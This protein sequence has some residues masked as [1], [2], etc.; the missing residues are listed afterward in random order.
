M[1]KQDIAV[2]GLS[3]LFPG[4]DT[5]D[6]FWENL[7]DNKD[8]RSLADN[9]QMGRNAKSFLGKPGEDDSFYCIDGGYI[10]DFS[11]DAK[12]INLSEEKLA[13]LD[14]VY[15]WALY[16]AR[17]ALKDSGYLNALTD[18]NAGVILGNLSFPTKK[19]NQLFIPMYHQAINNALIKH[20]KQEDFILPRYSQA[21]NA[22]REA[23]LLAG[24]PASIIA[25]A[26]GLKASQFC[27]DAACA[28]SIYSVKLACDYL[29][30]GRSDLM[31]AGAVS[32]ADPFFVNL[33]FS[34]F[35][36]YPENGISAPLDTRSQGLF[37]GEGAGM[38]VLKRLD[39]AL[40]DGDNIRAVIKGGGLSNDGKGQHVLSPNTKGQVKAF[41]RAYDN[42]AINPA[43]I[44][45]I[46]C[47]ATGTP[48]GDKVELT[49]LENFFSPH[50]KKANSKAPH[51]GSVKSNLGHL[52]TAAGMPAMTKVILGMD[53]GVIPASINIKEKQQSPKGIFSKDQ[54]SSENINWETT[55]KQKK[56][57]GVSVFG[58]GGANAHMIFEEPPQLTKD[59]SK[60][61]Q[62]KSSP[63]KPSAFKKRLLITGMDAHFGNC[64]NLAELECLILDGKSN[65]TDLP[66]KRWKGLDQDDLLKQSLGDKIPKGAYIES[67]DLDFLNFRLP[68]HIDERLMPQ[69]LLLMKVVDNALK[70]AQVLKGGNVA[71]LVA[72]GTELELHQ[73]RARVNLSAQFDELWQQQGKDCQFTEQQKNEIESLSKNTIHHRAQLN[74]YTSAIGN[75]MASRISALWD[76]SGP[77]FTVSA[78]ENS[79]FQAIEIAQLMFE[80]EDVD[81]VVVAA[82]DLSGSI[83]SLL[84]RQQF[85]AIH[86]HDNSEESAFSFDI[87]NQGWTVG[88]GAG[89]IVLEA[90]VFK[91]EKIESEKIKEK[92]NSKQ[93]YAKL[94]AIA[95][96]EGNTDESL[97]IASKKALS[98]CNYDFN[99]LEYW[100]LSAS[101]F[102]EQ[103]QM[104]LEAVLELSKLDAKNTTKDSLLNNKSTSLAIGSVK[105]NVGHCF[106]ASGISSVIKTALCLHNRC[107]PG[108]PNWHGPKNKQEQWHQSSLYIPSYSKTWFKDK[109]GA[110]RHAAVNSI[111]IDGRCY[112]LA[113]SENDEMDHDR[114]KNNISYQISPLEHIR[115]NNYL[116]QSIGQIFSFYGKDTQSI[117]SKLS[118]F[119]D[120][121]SEDYG[122]KAK[123]TSFSYLASEYYVNNKAHAEKEQQCLVI[124]ANDYA[125]LLQEIKLAKVGLVKADENNQDWFSPNGS[126]YTPKPLGKK[127]KVSF[128]YPG[129][130]NSYI[131]I[132]KD[133]AQLF[134][135][136]HNLFSRHSDHSARLFSDKLYYPR[137]IIPF[138]KAT[139]KTW[140]KSLYDEAISSFE[141]GI[142]VSVILTD[143]LKDIFSVKPDSAFGYSMGEVSMMYALGI[144]G[145]TDTMSER[146][147]S[148][149]VFQTRLAGPM[150]TLREQWQLDE[151]AK[152]GSFWSGFV[153]LAPI[154]KVREAI[155]NEK[156]VRLI[157]INT[158]NEVVIAGKPEDCRRVA[159][160][161]ACDFFEA[162]L[163]DVIHCDWVRK[164]YDDLAALHI[165]D[166]NQ[167]EDVDFFTAV[168]NKKL[169]ID[170]ENIA[171]NIAEMYCN[172]VDFVKLT[173]QVYEN[174][175]RIFIELGARDNSSRHIN[176]ILNDKEHVAISLNRKGSSDKN[177]LLKALAKLTSH[178]VSLD[179]SRLYQLANI[180]KKN[181][182]PKKQLLVNIEVGGKRITDEIKT[183]N[184]NAENYLS[185]KTVSNPLISRKFSS[186]ETI[187]NPTFE[188]EGSVTIKSTAETTVS[189]SS[190]NSSSKSY[191]E[192]DDKHT[193][194]KKYSMPNAVIDGFHENIIY[195]AKTHENFLEQRKQSLKSMQGL[196]SAQ[197][198]NAQLNKSN[199]INVSTKKTT[200]VI[201]DER[202]VSNSANF[203][204]SKVHYPH[205][206]LEN[207]IWGPDD[208][209]EFA[210]GNIA[211]VF[212]DAY[213]VIDSYPRRVRLPTKEY[214]LVD[215]VT[216]LNAKVNE[217]KKSFMTTEYDVPYDFW[218]S[219]KGQIPWA[220][221][222][223]SG[224][225]DLLLISY[226]GIDF[227]NKGERVYRLLDCEL[228]F[229]D[230]V[231]MEGDTLRYDIS[232]NSYARSGDGFLFFFSYN[233]FVG[234][235][236]VL[237]MRNGVAGFFN[238][239]ELNAGKGVIETEAEEKRRLSIVKQSFTPLLSCSKTS[240]DYN[241]MLSLCEGDISACFGDNYAQDSVKGVE[242]N[243]NLV[244]SAPKMLM[245]E[246]IT[247]L[248]PKGGAWGLGLIVGEK[249]LDPD[250]WYF[251]CHF[252]DDQV[253]AGSLMSDG[254]S[255]LLRFYT[256]YLGLHTLTKDAVFQ[257]I[258]GLG[259]QVRCRGQVVPQ[260]AT[261]SYR[262]EI[263]EIGTESAPYAK[264]NVDIILNGKVVVD[265]KNLG[266]FLGEIAG[267]DLEKKINRRKRVLADDYAEASLNINAN[268]NETTSADIN[269][270]S[271][272]PLKSEL[273]IE[274]KTKVAN[275]IHD[276]HIYIPGKYQIREHPFSPFPNNPLDQNTLPDTLPYTQFHLIEFATGRIANC[277]GETFGGI[278]DGRTPPRT[279]NA[280]LQLTTRVIDIKGER[281][282]LKQVSS[283]VAEFDVPEDAWFYTENMHPELM[284]YSMIMEIA[285]QPNGF[286]SAWVGTTLLFPEK[287][288]FFR[289]LDGSGTLLKELALRG[290]TITNTST[291]LSTTAAGNTIIQNFKFN[292]SVDGDIFYEGTS[293]FGYFLKDA[294][295][296]QLG[297]DK[298]VILKPWHIENTIENSIEH[299]ENNDVLK[300]I[301]LCSDQ[302]RHDFYIAKTNKPYFCLAKP[303]LNLLDKAVVGKTM[304]KFGLGYIY[305]EKTIDP[306]DWFFPCHFHQ[307][308]VMPGSLGVEAM[309]QAMQIWAIDNDLGHDFHNPR[310][311][312]HLAKTSWKY[313]G[314]IIPDNKCM[315]LDMHI[316]AIDKQNN[317]LVITASGSLYKDGLRIYEL[318]DAQLKI[319]EA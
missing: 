224:Q 169:T 288:L 305:A 3:G 56:R 44:N 85:G 113:L 81:A 143:L 123:D 212:G 84:L 256:W 192:N 18:I 43:S 229:M 8:C 141:N 232:I 294:L 139:E 118:V 15:Q 283:T 158:Q 72:M 131:N 242:L 167:V 69:Q 241:D 53:K 122:D 263:T 37:A 17:E 10:H 116:Y 219:S 20:L 281:N 102:P 107:I 177:N 159:D 215:R 247:E 222:V 280:D 160:K 142:S 135:E 157:L 86:S 197:L 42:A 22:S 257:P 204:Q 317:A 258:S 156:Y 260:H 183:L 174:G 150:D 63:S 49:S 60:P 220:V 136:L 133:L 104:E 94:D 273:S 264:A 173:N 275:V 268:A 295:S 147:R 166:V 312:H 199:E 114:R 238:D 226:L 267:T 218:Y 233:C 165:L 286:I 33:G 125:S 239:E 62:L 154:S 153:L 109:N 16:V 223:E 12:D 313:R 64:K 181:T 140:Q 195:M 186:Q 299:S 75:I 39:D 269:S 277:F 178:G 61:L 76:F 105:N 217:Y 144:W 108:I 4:S 65:F 314:Q 100:E 243:P 162:A 117:L 47:H 270:A 98:D 67:F 304:G 9:K 210:E 106:A 176:Q 121:L 205:A 255:Q 70:D 191:S 30:T 318:I 92:Q 80:Q 213:K 132:V 128:V 21:E 302:A 303:Q 252:K 291:L 68:P 293:V 50:I 221:A 187:P 2:I 137:S 26:F 202:L 145:A 126:F 175:A 240:F 28:S 59:S 259:Q 99:D 278:Y 196:L 27:L 180:P 13:S 235:K 315:S 285:L 207:V 203:D 82:V 236:L 1:P 211:N 284:P 58:F 95:F 54:I 93:V 262:M 246:R 231:A 134:P 163:G 66:E 200:S 5:L 208:L 127:G 124:L 103:D 19:S 274:S 253:M 172:P 57:A 73:I 189:N 101:G 40:A 6:K 110:T 138:D 265:F 230:D 87:S 152:D 319:S 38:L 179:L 194:I 287:D 51:I 151:T 237:K 290:K 214:L 32:A 25:Q 41:E 206:D 300:T 271:V 184:F 306:N 74:Q 45:Y 216:R 48:L 149:P 89:A 227:Q 282:N 188:S 198:N 261:L 289:N 36:A 34:V 254:C 31:L 146:L 296:H 52:L 245:I 148:N 129:A 168:G 301:D 161:L 316:S 23:G 201:F 35:H 7:I 115:R 249:T 24:Y 171:S 164:D 79:A 55:P 292:L 112:F 155:N 130:F 97:V 77:A 91:D 250:H 190:A 310:F 185:Q 119:L 225:C 182:S 209:V 71:V 14:D 120:N 276:G 251:P 266:L 308:P 279:P 309:L 228:T 11:M 272:Q 298:G 96:A 46:E 311:S 78:E 111:G 88:E 297:M 244:Y 307:D 193:T 248:D 234:D 83:E 90:D 29:Q 170:S